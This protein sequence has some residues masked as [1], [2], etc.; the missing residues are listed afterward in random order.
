[1]PRDDNSG[2]GRRVLVVDDSRLVR[3]TVRKELE[4]AKYDVRCAESGEEAFQ[5]C[6]DSSFDLIVTDVAMGTLSG[7]QLC[8]ILRGDPNTVD[9][10]ILLLTAADDAR[11]RFWGKHAGANA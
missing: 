9:V 11:S 10:P 4:R 5:L 1:M 6:I 7:M 8:R 2:R 3:S